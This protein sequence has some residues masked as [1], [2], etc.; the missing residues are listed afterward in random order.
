MKSKKIL[1]DGPWIF[2]YISVGIEVRRTGDRPWIFYYISVGGDVWRTGKTDPVFHSTL[3]T[4]V[5][6]K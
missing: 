1:E 3:Y 5:G 6:V 2:L 4:P